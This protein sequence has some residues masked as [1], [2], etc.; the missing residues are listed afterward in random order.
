MQGPSLQYVF[1]YHGNRLKADVLLTQ[2]TLEQLRFFNQTSENW[3]LKDYA[4]GTKKT[5]KAQ[6]A[7][8]RARCLLQLAYTIAFTCLLRVDEVLKIQC[9]DIK[10]V[11]NSKGEVALQV[12]LPF[13]K[14]EQFGGASNHPLQHY[15]Y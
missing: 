15:W 1:C 11:T 8:G 9:H 10:L 6:W 2:K 7:G 12:T 13:R 5:A 3:D 4:P 14:T